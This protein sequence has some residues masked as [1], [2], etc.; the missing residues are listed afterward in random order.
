MPTH[1]YEEQVEQIMSRVE[2]AEEIHDDNKELIQDY[3]RD[4]R[5]D[6]IAP[7]T[8]QKYLAYLVVVGKHVGNTRFED[9]DKEDMK[10]LVAW[11]Q[12]KDHAPSTVDTYKE[13]IRQF[14]SWLY[15]EDG[16]GEYPEEVA[17]ITVDTKRSSGKLPSDLL[18]E[19]DVEAQI[20]A[21]H[22]A[23]DKALIAIL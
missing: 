9:M 22:H 2:E 1:D 18:T 23:R 17:W 5:L 16:K 19:D 13:I 10:D 11:V 21:C 6:G 8:Q 14:W 7:A 4:L 15:D 12:S 20:E 3:H